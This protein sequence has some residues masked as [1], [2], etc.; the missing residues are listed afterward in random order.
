MDVTGLNLINPPPP[1]GLLTHI[2][3]EISIEVRAAA[4]ASLR[5]LNI[6]EQQRRNNSIF[7]M[8]GCNDSD[9]GSYIHSERPFRSTA[10][11][12]VSCPTAGSSGSW[13]LD[14]LVRL[15]SGSALWLVDN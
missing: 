6:Y 13:V 14:S 5:G 12:S 10:G 9:S 1:T 2:V 3:A 11:S 4:A 8:S 7:R 15:N